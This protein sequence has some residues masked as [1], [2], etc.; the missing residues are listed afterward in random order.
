MKIGELAER[1]GLASSRIRFYERIGL[2]QLVEREPN[3]YRSY[4]PEA[5]LVLHLIAAA[6]QAGF[7]LDELRTLLPPDLAQWQRGALL[8]ALRR[9]LQDIET[10]QARL[11]QSRAQ[12]VAVM[13]EIEAKPQDVDCATN[14][15]KMLSRLPLGEEQAAAKP[16][17]RKA[18]GRT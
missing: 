6:Q 10:L 14:A 3:G 13:A 9:K 11:A 4:P 15:R 18:A 17:R 2:L 8:D 5:V 16:R 1:T 12:L 7:S